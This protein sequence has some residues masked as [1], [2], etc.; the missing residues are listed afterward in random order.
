M[1]HEKFITEFCAAW[2]TG[3]VEAIVGAFTPD[4]VY[5]NVPMEPCVGIDAIREFVVDFFANTASSVRF[6]IRNQVLVGNLLMNE[7]IDTIVM[8]TGEVEL[9]VCGVF[10]LSADG[11]IAGWRDYFDMG[12]FA[13]PAG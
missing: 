10:E 3:D 2:G 13:G 8:E 7:R 12:P 4:A 11:K 9:P 1:D 5:H 6:D